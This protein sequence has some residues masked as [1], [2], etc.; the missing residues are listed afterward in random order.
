ML[1][2]FRGGVEDG[3]V[4][5]GCGRGGGVL[6]AGVMVGGELRG[7]GQGRGSAQGRKVVVAMSGAIRAQRR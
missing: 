6:R 7:W 1:A 3:G 4:L 5:W 2:G